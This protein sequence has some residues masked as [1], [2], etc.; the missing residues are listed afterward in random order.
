[1]PHQVPDGYSSLECTLPAAKV[2]DDVPQVVRLVMY[3][4]LE[5]DTGTTKTDSKTFSGSFVES[6]ADGDAFTGYDSA[7]QAIVAAVTRDPRWVIPLVRDS[8]TEPW[9]RVRLRAFDDDDENDFSC[10]LTSYNENGTF[11][12]PVPGEQDKPRGNVTIEFPPPS[13]GVG[14]ATHVATCSVPR[15]RGT[16]LFMYDI[17]EK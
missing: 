13:D 10:S 3:R 15:K 9:D 16:V 1:M 7:N 6:D 2:V 5:I 11:A 17:R 14:S 4:T 12:D 8:V